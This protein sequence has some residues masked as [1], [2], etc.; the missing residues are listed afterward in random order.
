M[1]KKSIKKPAMMTSQEYKVYKLLCKTWGDWLVN[2]L[3]SRYK[4]KPFSVR[5]AFERF[6]GVFES[7]QIAEAIIEDEIGKEFSWDD[8]FFIEDNHYVY[9]FK[10]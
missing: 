10:K 2:A 7:K 9:V 3:L 4:S 5:E 1:S 8:Y 6:E